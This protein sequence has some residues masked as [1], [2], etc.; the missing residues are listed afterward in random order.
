V[1]ANEVGRFGACAW[2]DYDNDGYFDLIVGSYGPN[3]N[4]LYHNNRDGTFSKVINDI[5]ATDPIHCDS[6][7]WGDYDNDG[8]LDLL[9][10]GEVS[11]YQHAF[12]YHNNGDGS[13]AKVTTGSP[14]NDVGEGRA[15][16][17]VDY[18]RDGFLDIW[19]A[20]SFGYL[21][22]LYRNTGNTNGWLDVKCQGRLSNRAAI[23]AKLRLKA[24]I[25]GKS[26]WQLRQITATETTGHFGVGDA[27]SIDILRIEWPSGMVQQ[28]T[29]VAPRQFITIREPS[30]LS[31]TPGV[32][33]GLVTL[34]LSGAKGQIYAIERSTDVVTWE[35][36]K[37]V[38]NS[39]ARQII[40]DTAGAPAL[41]Y[42]AVEQP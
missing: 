26:F 18:D 33:D 23:G 27:T 40:S 17:F 20:R 11:P 13:F 5:V 25:R 30:K 35:D 24:T 21:N 32:Q 10:S 15:C 1:V 28:F 22:G 6:T 38:T 16:A 39:A 34:T 9:V 42:R 3:N 12:L 37:R 4:V 19:V 41:F 2:G 31:A 14:V 36:W 8:Y 7:V 29:N